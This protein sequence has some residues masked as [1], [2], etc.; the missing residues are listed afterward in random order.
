MYHEFIIKHFY[1]L[2]YYVRTIINIY[3]Y[4]IDND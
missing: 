2:H 3:I 1:D 4:C